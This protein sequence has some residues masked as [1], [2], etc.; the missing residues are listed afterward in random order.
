MAGIILIFLTNW[1]GAVGSSSEFF[2]ATDLMRIGV[3]YYPEAWPS[4]Q[5]ARDITNFKKLD[6]EFVHMGEFTWAFMELKRGSL[7]SSGWIKISSFA[8][9]KARR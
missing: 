3:Y 9:N 6:M 7:I 2:P 4:E 5:W 8:R 1:A